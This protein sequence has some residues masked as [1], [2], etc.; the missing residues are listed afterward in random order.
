MFDKEAY[1][2]ILVYS[3]FL[4]TAHGESNRTKDPAYSC[5]LQ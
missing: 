1:F 5:P 4:G 2:C 3:T